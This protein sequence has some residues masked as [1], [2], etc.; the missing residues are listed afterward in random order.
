LKF[1]E[2]HR[3]IRGKI[4][5]G[6]DMKGKVLLEKKEWGYN[7]GKNEKHKVLY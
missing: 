5:F 3:N 1:P 4:I 6:L 2:R 7:K